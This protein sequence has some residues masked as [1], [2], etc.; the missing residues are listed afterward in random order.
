MIFLTSLGSKKH[1]QKKL[2]QTISIIIF[3]V[4]LLGALLCYAFVVQTL[5]NKREKLGRLTSALK[6]RART[7]KFMLDGFPK[8]FLPKDLTLLVQRSLAD[9][10]EDLAQLEPENPAHMNDYQNISAQMTESQ[11]QPKPTKPVLLNNP[12]QINDVKKCLE[13]LNKFV[14]ALEAKKTV[15][16]PQ[17]A[18]YRQQIKQMVLKLTVDNYMLQGGKFRQNGKT[19]LALHYYELALNLMLKEGTAGQHD[20]QISQIKSILQELKQEPKQEH[21]DSSP[22]SATKTEETADEWSEYAKTD[23]SWKKNN[24][25]D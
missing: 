7:F 13:E 12:Q 5:K 15:S 22:N 25:Y 9:V 17:S 18:E 4:I 23:S 8:G 21:Q 14:N 2:M 1:K 6:N 11:R 10:C 19:P 16:P 24:I 3:I 20:A